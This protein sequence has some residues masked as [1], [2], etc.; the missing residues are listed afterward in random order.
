M[1]KEDLIKI[2]DVLWEIPKTYKR[3]MLVPARIYAKEEMLDALLSDRSLEQLV[4][5]STLPGAQ[6]AVYVMPDAHEGYGFPIGEWR[7]PAIQMVLFHREASDTIS[8][9]ESG[10]FVPKFNLRIL[11]MI[12]ELFPRRCTPIF[13]VEWVREAI[14]N[15]RPGRWTVF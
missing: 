3:G 4:N 6:K 9:A 8:T 2:S 12:W 7:L 11:R 1:K 5:V 14:L 13:P 10:C 15:Y